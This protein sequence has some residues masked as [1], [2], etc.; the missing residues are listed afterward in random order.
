MKVITSNF[1]D[2]NYKNLNFKS[3]YPVI[4]WIVK[5]NNPVLVTNFELSK[6]MNTSLVQT[7]NKCRGIINQ[8]ILELK[9]STSKTKVK[10]LNTFLL[11]QRVQNF[12][13]SIDQSYADK[14]IA[15]GFNTMQGGLD[16][17]RY[18]PYSYILTGIEA[19]NFSQTYANP[20]RLAYHSKAS[21][22]VIYEQKRFY[23]YEGFNYILEKAKGFTNKKGEPKELHV[24]LR[25]KNNDNY[26]IACMK[27][28]TD[29]SPDHPFKNNDWLSA[30]HK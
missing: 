23:G 15:C 21:E 5:N 4:Y 9:N 22:E 16:N 24:I 30:E 12:I 7:L 28:F 18:K 13:R 20:I 6:K 8:K 27:F 10:K 26:E 11:K 29:S 1:N 25:P 19:Q 3:A 17:N 2:L 14:P